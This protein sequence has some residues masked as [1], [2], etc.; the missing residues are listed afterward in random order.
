MSEEKKFVTWEEVVVDFLQR[1]KEA[2][3]EAYLKDEIKE[4]ATLYESSMFSDDDDLKNFFD[5]KKNKKAKEQSAVEFQRA[6][7]QQIFDLDRKPDDFDQNKIENTYSK[8][9]E[10]IEAKFEPYKWIGQASTDASSVTFAT[11]VF[12]LTHSKIDSKALLDQVDSKKDEYLTTSHIKNKIIDGA[13]V[14]NQ[15]APVYQFLELEFDGKKLAEEFRDT[16]SKALESFAKDRE[17]LLT[18]NKGFVRALVSDQPQTHSLAKQIYFPLKQEDAISSDSYHLLTNVKSS[19]LA[20]AL[21]LKFSNKLQKQISSLQQ[22]N[23][24]SKLSK[25]SFI[26]QAA[27]MV[28]QSNHGNASQL[29]GKRGGRL[30]LLSTQPPSWKGQLKPPIFV[31]SFFYAIPWSMTLKENLDYLRDFLL[32]FEQIE[33]SIKNPKRMK[34]IERWVEQIIDEIFAYCATI[35][36][37]PSGWSE[38]KDIKLKKE[39]RYFLDPFRV[40]EIFQAERK[41]KEWQM[42]VSKDFADWLNEKLKGKDKSFTPQSEHTRIWRQLLEEQLREFDEPI[43]ME[44]KNSMRSVV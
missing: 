33:L 12:K 40:D 36:N 23:K 44:I 31:T 19:S 38:D 4:I 10:E 15:Y 14:G 3:E 21:H 5:P 30:A 41:T 25:T 24:Y 27:L 8:R 32:R 43:K 28:T 17:E 34:W 6:K 37:L 11:H 42:V 9:L 29:N 39:H 7:L 20:H 22:K 1:K 16:S 26:G 35:Q 2:I 13:V 18:W